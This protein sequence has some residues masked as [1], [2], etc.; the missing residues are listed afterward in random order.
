[1]GYNHFSADVLWDFA[2]ED[3]RD[4][5]SAVVF[6]KGALCFEQ[7]DSSYVD[8][9][10]EL[11]DAILGALLGLCSHHVAFRD[12]IDPEANIDIEIRNEQ[13]ALHQALVAAA[14][15]RQQLMP[16]LL[17]FPW[18]T[19]LMG[20]KRLPELVRFLRDR[21]EAMRQQKIETLDS[22]SFP[23]WSPFLQS[24][25]E[26]VDEW[27]REV[28]LFATELWSLM[29]LAP[30][31]RSV[32]RDL[33]VL[34]R[35]AA[36]TEVVCSALLQH[37]L[38]AASGDAVAVAS[39]VALADAAA[40]SGDAVL[41][42]VLAHLED[43]QRQRVAEMLRSTAPKAEAWAQLLEAAPRHAIKPR[44]LRQKV[45]SPKMQWFKIWKDTE[46]MV[47]PI[48]NECHGH[49]VED[50]WGIR[51]NVLQYMLQY[52][53]IWLYGQYRVYLWSWC[54]QEA[55]QATPA[56]PLR[57]EGNLGCH[58]AVIYGHL[59]RSS[60]HFCPSMSILSMLMLLVPVL[61]LSRKMYY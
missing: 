27:R 32:L 36:P 3:I 18:R 8:D 7:A 48:Q 14:A 54:G 42:A 21:S 33:A 53:A 26:E 23:R 46:T 39:L 6:A 10:P 41:S 11:R 19:G 50:S 25:G 4:A 51:C 13:L 9:L 31:K 58:G 20:D 56:E 28:R 55:P 15:A 59:H 1:M 29:D 45:S 43:S 49:E 30:P 35:V 22:G 24:L 34:A 40:A 61:E 44:F 60:Q 47:F 17:A 37:G 12:C 57:Q 38:A 16:C 2:G 5:Y 52:V